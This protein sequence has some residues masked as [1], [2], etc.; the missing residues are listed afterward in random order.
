MTE[1]IFPKDFLWGAA[2]AS[3]Q[4][5]GAWNED[6][7]GESIWD[8]Y[9]HTPG[10]IKNGDTGDVACDHY[11]RWQEDLDLMKSLHLTAYRFSIAWPRLFPEGRGSL[12]A[13]GLDF[14]S[15]LVDG[16]L[17]RGIAP[18][19][20]LYHW[21]LPQALQDA[22]GWLNRRTGDWFAEY[23]H[24]VAKALGDRIPALMT[25][26]EPNIV[27]VCGFELG[28][29]APGVKDKATSLQVLH[30]LLLAHGKA[31]QAI[32]AEKPG[33]RVGI[34][35]SVSMEYPETQDAR[36]L[37]RTQQAWEEANGWHLEPC[38]LGRYPASLWAQWESEGLAPLVAP[39]DLALIRQP[40]DFLAVNHYFSTVWGHDARGEAVKNR[41]LSETTGLHWPIHPEGLRDV[42]LELDKRY[43]KRPYIISENGAAYFN[44]KPGADGKVHDGERV[45]YLRRYLAAAG[46]ALERGVDLRGYFVW[47]LMDNFEW[48]HGYEPQF[49]IT[50]VDFK[51]LKRTVKDSGL[52]YAQTAKAG[53]L[54]F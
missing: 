5:E 48:S 47:T 31:V 22:G 26:N 32:R 19:P 36:D 34:A 3:Y 2:T 50:H 12:N 16:L 11:H 20:T 27:A 13:K 7:R 17:K 39:G 23:A 51:T 49:G 43:G 9:A 52:F 28:V 44:E 6:G 24:Q 40:L 46:E 29:Q 38:L 25:L 14:Y 30:H 41:D 10:K 54:I 37:A 35:P 53:R 4:I 18:H 33:L 15:R 42:L 21:D 1:K 8:R 45:D